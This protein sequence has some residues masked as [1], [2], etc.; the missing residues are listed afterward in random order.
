MGLRLCRRK[1]PNNPLQPPAGVTC[2][3]ESSGT[4]ARGG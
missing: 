2:E 3:L 4:F 1:L